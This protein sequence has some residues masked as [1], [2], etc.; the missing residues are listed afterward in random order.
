MKIFR[1]ILLVAAVL[2][3]VISA[4]GL[5]FFSSH[6]HVERSIVIKQNRTAMFDYVNDLKNYQ[7]WSPWFE[8]DTAAKYSY[9]GSASG[10][11]AIMSWESKVKSVG[12]GNM[13]ITDVIKDSLINVDLDFMKNGV[14]KSSYSFTTQ[15][16]STKMTW[17]LDYEAGANP[18]LRIMGKFMDG[19]VGDDFQKG[20]NKLKKLV[21]NMPVEDNTLKVE[22][23]AIPI[24]DYLFV[25]GKANEKNIGLFLGGSY[26]KIGVVIKKQNLT[27]SGAPFAIYYT[28]S[29]TEWEMD[30]CV[31]VSASA[32]N[33]GDVKAG[34]MNSGNAVV[35]HF[36]G[37]Y[38]QTKIAYTVLKEYIA[39][40]NKQI[41]GA[42]WEVY[43]TDPMAEK[44]TAKWQTDVYF[45]IH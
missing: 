10:A 19:I 3:L 43:I 37:S 6:V 23:V 5:L 39:S 1:K 24:S 26:Q 9:S 42:P 4:I 21:E 29:Q 36:F 8:L 30:A 25:H 20:L 28:D 15:N 27:M 35:A 31:P 32:K 17:G 14:A 40:H 13:K 16:D 11:G 44:D 41:V 12:S 34:K 22:E 7:K 18:I 38:D 33:E 45:P 2:L